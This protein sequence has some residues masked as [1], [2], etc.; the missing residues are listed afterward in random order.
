MQRNRSNRLT[1]NAYTDKRLQIISFPLFK[2]ITKTNDSNSFYTRFQCVYSTKRG[3]QT[4]QMYSFLNAINSKRVCGGSNENHNQ[5][6]SG[7]FGFNGVFFFCFLHID[8]SN[9]SE[10]AT[11]FDSLERYE[12]EY[13]V[14]AWLCSWR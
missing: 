4:C 1:R 5:C 2:S 3:E 10:M 11:K 13:S 12:G 8:W 9:E 14:Y 7:H 6:I